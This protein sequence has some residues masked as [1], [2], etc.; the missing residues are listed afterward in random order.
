MSPTGEGS[1]CLTA[2]WALKLQHRNFTIIYQAEAIHQNSE[3]LSI[4]PAIAYLA[5]KDDRMFNF[6]SCLNLCNQEPRGAGA[7]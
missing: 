2:Q 4:L 6:V 5:P 7:P 1:Q 3:G